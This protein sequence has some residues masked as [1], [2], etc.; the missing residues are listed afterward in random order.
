MNLLVSAVGM[1]LGVFIVVAPHRAAALWGSEGMRLP[2]SRSTIWP[3]T[4]NGGPPLPDSCPPRH[5]SRCWLPLVPTAGPATR[6]RQLLH[7]AVSIVWRV[8]SIATTHPIQIGRAS[9]RERVQI[10]VGA[11]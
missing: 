1:A 11:V 10:S 9:C 4:L 8:R 7:R 6:L 5:F 3:A 2:R